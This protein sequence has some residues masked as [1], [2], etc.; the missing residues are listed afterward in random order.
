MD[1]Q[2]LKD[3]FAQVAQH[4][5]S[6][7]LFFYSDL[8]LRKPE[9]RDMFPIGMSHQR[10]RL[11]S[12][13]GRIVS[14]VDDLPEIISF[15]RQLGADHRKFGVEALHFP[16]VGQSLVTTLRYFSGAGWND[17]LAQD[18][19]D[20]YNTVAKV[21]IEGAEEDAVH[22]PAWWN[23][24][25]VAHDRR[26]FDLAVMRV[27][28]D[29]PL[30]F[31]PG[32]AV[33]VETQARP[34]MWR[35]YSVANAPRPDNTIDFHVRLVDGGPVSP[36]LVRSVGIGDWLRLGAPV[37]TMTFDERSGRDVLLIGGSTGLAPLKSILDRIATSPAPPRVHLFFG[38]RTMDG[39]Y[40]LDDLSKR[41]AE[42][43]WLT[44]V[45]AVSDED[46]EG[47]VHQGALAD[48]VAR[49]GPWRDHDAYVCGSPAMV[50]ATADRLLHLGLG[51]DRIRIDKFADA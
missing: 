50:D 45:P 38:A 30:P 29:R 51:V 32:Q 15:V 2:A 9:L 43:P 24:R 4:G 18:W 37:G 40:D 44:V 19:L 16:E 8:F 13:L 1:A 41:A 22:R 5:D 42:N 10:D 46:A 31:E 14:Q 11:L 3:N 33:A 36:V 25:I 20:A 49:N 27:E 26:R 34:R 28:T 21:M 35:Y 7:A 39:L 48:V 23:A 47:G 17:Q 6:V 12:A